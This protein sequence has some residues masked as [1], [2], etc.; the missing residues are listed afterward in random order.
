M[1]EISIEELDSTVGGNQQWCE[2]AEGV[3]IAV[4]VSTWWSGVGEGFAAALAVGVLIAC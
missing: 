4:A 3:A 1:S 2:F